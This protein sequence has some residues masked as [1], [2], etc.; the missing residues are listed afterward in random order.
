MRTMTKQNTTENSHVNENNG[1]DGKY[2]HWKCGI[3][4]D[5]LRQ[6]GNSQ[7]ERH[8]D[9]F[10]KQGPVKRNRAKDRNAHI[11]QKLLFRALELETDHFQ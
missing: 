9:R 8:R 10:V 11:W 6:S 7:E 1:F 3:V 4:K 2:I 5:I